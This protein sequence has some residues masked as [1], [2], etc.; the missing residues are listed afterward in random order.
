VSRFVIGATWDDAPHLSQQARTD[1]WGSIP[2]YQR[3][4]RTKGIPQLGAG[5]IY[6]IPEADITCEPFDIPPTWRRGF[7]QDVGWNRTAG[8]WGA[9][10]P[11]TGIAYLYSTHYRG[12]AEPPVHAEAWKARGLWIPG[13]IDPAARGR[14]QIDGQRLIT[15]YSKLGL[16]LEKAQNAVESGIYIVWTGLSSG[17]IKVFKTLRDWF[18][19]YRMYQRDEKGRIKKTKDHLMDSTRYLFAS[20]TDWWEARP[21]G[22]REDGHHETQPGGGHVYYGEG[23]RELSWMM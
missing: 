21:P 1:L 3:D 12:E 6:P 20:G 13:R 22:W 18:S 8:V 15:I 5:A 19:E 9:L 14:S 11:N 23:D 10:D 17:K 2:E 7:G 16:K 4:A